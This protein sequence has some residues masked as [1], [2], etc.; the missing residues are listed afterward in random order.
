MRV[1]N[2]PNSALTSS[3]AMCRSSLQLL[4]VIPDVIWTLVTDYSTGKSK[5]VSG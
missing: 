4:R 1:N 3:K 2:R 5:K